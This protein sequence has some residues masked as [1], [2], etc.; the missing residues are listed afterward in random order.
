MGDK[1]INLIEKL[2]DIK[3]S[4]LLSNS[5]KALIFENISLHQFYDL[6]YV[7]ERIK[8]H[9]IW[10]FILLLKRG[11][12]NLAQEQ[13]DHFFNCGLLRTRERHTYGIQVRSATLW[14]QGYQN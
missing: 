8:L 6:M 3:R 14:W 4:D 9:T 1:L 12:D 7:I 11:V 5:F 13:K 2:D 10:D